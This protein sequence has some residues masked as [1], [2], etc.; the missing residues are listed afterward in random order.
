L[1]NDRVLRLKA[2]ARNVAECRAA[3]LH[4]MTPLRDDV[5]MQ[6]ANNFS[7]RWFSRAR[8]NEVPSA[9]GGLPKNQAGFAGT[10][11]IARS[12]THE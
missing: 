11:G 2:M 4:E 10:D 7:T 3:S 12:T 8:M 9:Y 1:S 5:E 6:Y